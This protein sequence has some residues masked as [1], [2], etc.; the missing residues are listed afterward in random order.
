[1][2]ICE[3]TQPVNSQNIHIAFVSMSGW[4]FLWFKIARNDMFMKFCKKYRG[5]IMLF[6]LMNIY[7]NV[8]P[9]PLYKVYNAVRLKMPTYNMTKLMVFEI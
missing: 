7:Q 1:M 3:T 4:I 8:K 6:Y 2:A 5:K 9:R